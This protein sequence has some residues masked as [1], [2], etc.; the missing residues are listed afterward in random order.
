MTSD[1]RS[2][3]AGNGSMLHVLSSTMLQNVVDVSEL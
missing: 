3:H 1:D 2:K